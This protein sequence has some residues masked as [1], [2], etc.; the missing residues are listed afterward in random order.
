MTIQDFRAKIFDQSVLRT[1]R[2]NVNIVLPPAVS[3]SAEDSRTLSLLAESVN[4]PGINFNTTQNRR[5]GYGFTEKYVNDTTFNDL[6]V[7]FITDGDNE[8][9]GIFRKWVNTIMP[10]DTF[11]FEYKSNYCAPGFKIDVKDEL[12]DTVVVYDIY[13]AFPISISDI[14]LDWNST[15]EIAKFTV[16]FSYAYWK[17]L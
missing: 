2:F 5:F 15:D 12:N 7:S 3:S 17:V 14:A 4:L 13:Y 9:L 6:T 1:S 10:T 11:L 8:V 16:T